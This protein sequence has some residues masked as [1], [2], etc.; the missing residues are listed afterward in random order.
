MPRLPIFSLLLAASTVFAA[1]QKETLPAG[2]V[3]RL[4]APAP[5][6]KGETRPGAVNALAFLDENSLFVAT[7]AGWRAWDVAKRQ[8][9]Q[10]RPVGGPAFAVFRHADRLFVGSARK[11]HSIEPIQS[12]T[13]EA[14]RSWDSAADVV[15]VLAGFA[16]GGRVV[17]SEGDQK[18]TVLDVKT[19]KAT[20]AAEFASRPIAASL[21][22]N[23]R[24]LAV[25]TRD[26]AARVYHLSAN[27]TLDPL[28][29]KRVARSD[30][31]AAQFSPDG[32]LLA[33]STAGRVMIL[34]AVT[35]RPMQSVER[36]FGEGD[37]R[38]LTF[39]PDGKQV[40]IGSTGPDPIVRV[41][42]VVT[43]HEQATF[44][45]HSGD[46]NA[47]AF[48]PDGRTLASGGTDQSVILWKVP[49][50][51]PGPMLITTVE[52]WETLDSLDADVAYRSMGTLLGQP[53]RAISV[54][55]DG[56][57]GTADEQ[58][59]IR[60]WIAELDHDEF[61]VRET[62]RR[63]L[64]KAGLRAAAALNDAGRKKM[65]VEGENRVRLILEA[66]ES[67][68][69]RIPESGLFGEPLRGVRGVRVLESIGGP[70]ARAVLEEVAKGPAESRLTKEAKGALET[71]PPAR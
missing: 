45:G 17:F 58:V 30:R 71:L 8:P 56:Y 19:G 6:A 18:L 35:G 32:R 29:S 49:A 37:V 23:G 25:V 60:R 50:P 46:V 16:D 12:A 40:A 26:G 42:D 44:V 13:V 11:L 61:R 34:D 28:W 66:M 48:A 5:T 63:S 43:A 27:G 39:S 22:A 59:K 1:P 68:G 69:V 21:T 57:R 70:E 62:A 2:A 20:G 65:G 36:R 15:G 24:V 41:A 10:E 38:C 7:D 54:I 53:G 64:L 33:V 51:P 9:R 4:G 31:V 47:V 52:A 3:A 67:Q 55:R 14:A